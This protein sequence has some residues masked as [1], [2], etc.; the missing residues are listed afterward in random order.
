MPLRR[1]AVCLILV[2][3]STMARAA[4][5][6]GTQWNVA[7]SGGNDSN[8]GAFDPTVGSPGTDESAT[9]GTSV[10]CVVQSTTTQVICTPA[11]SS[12]TNG[13]GNFIGPMTGSGCTGSQWNEELSQSGG[14][15]TFTTSFGSAASTCV[16]VLGGRLLTLG[17]AN[18]NAVL[19][20]IV[21]CSGTF[22]FASQLTL[23]Q[24]TMAFI[25][26]TST[27]GDGGRA[28]WSTTG[29]N[30]IINT[31]SSNGGI[32][33]FENISWSSSNGSPG[34]GIWQENGHG[35]TQ[36]WSFV[37]DKFSGF[38]TAIDSSDVIPYDVAWIS[39]SN[40][41]F[42]G[43]GS[44]II[45]NEATPLFVNGS[46]F[47]GDLQYDIQ[48]K[49]GS[50]FVSNSIF[51]GAVSSIL[52]GAAGLQIT[53]TNCTFYGNTGLALSMSGTSYA[54]IVN[55]I[56]YANSEAIVYGSGFV[57]ITSTLGAYNAFGA[58]TNPNS[59]WNMSPTDITLSANPFVNAS[60]GN[61]ALNT[62]AGGGALLAGRCIHKWVR[63]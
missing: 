41:E 62:T 57:S 39:V 19:G 6:P 30:A 23:S 51:S 1:I 44:G 38:S 42:T 20:N 63:A 22:T 12:T 27:K 58:N 35:T 50:A 14:T 45:T 40:S 13:P 54:T 43:N 48:P 21:W 34:S 61:F 16:G 36:G 4:F 53:V 56:F 2:C 55:N 15:G 28:T 25:G 11:L 17:Q 46:Y 7:S 3:L 26:Y 5:N 33:S 60:A 31:G 29:T 49:N 10:S 32:Q 24:V 8:G 59:D 37:N 18:T 9:S 52:I 47:H